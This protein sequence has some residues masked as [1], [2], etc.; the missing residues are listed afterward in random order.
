MIATK[1]FC[2]IPSSQIISPGAER[3]VKYG[4]LDG[5]G[6]SQFYCP[7]FHMLSLDINSSHCGFSMAELT[8]QPERAAKLSQV[9]G[10]VHIK[11]GS[12]PLGTTASPHVG[13]IGPVVHFWD[14]PR[15]MIMRRY[16]YP[17]SF[18]PKNADLY[19]QRLHPQLPT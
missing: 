12:I 15:A 19:L 8:G 7:L 10:P 17:A 1:S 5:S 6:A 9:C 4:L 14:Q 3:F 11:T 16:K 13:P 2:H 18:T